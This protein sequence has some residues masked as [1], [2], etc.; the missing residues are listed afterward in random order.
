V[1]GLLFAGMETL[2]SEKAVPAGTAG[3]VRFH[4]KA[5]RSLTGG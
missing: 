3:D 2:P 1:T 4:L 5:F